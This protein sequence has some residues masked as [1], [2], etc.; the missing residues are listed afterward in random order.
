MSECVGCKLSTDLECIRSNN[1]T[2]YKNISSYVHP[3]ASMTFY[4]VGNQVFAHFLKNS[5]E[6]SRKF[7]EFIYEG[8]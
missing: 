3:I 4:Q 6:H 8:L 2:A 1:V 7:Q 5:P